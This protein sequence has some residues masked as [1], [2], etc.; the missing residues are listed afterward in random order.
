MGHNVYADLGFENSEEMLIKAELVSRIGRIIEER[1]LTQEQVA[2]LM[3]LDQPKVSN[4]LRGRFQD[5][6]LNRIFQ[7]LVALDEDVSIVVGPKSDERGR[8][9]VVA[10]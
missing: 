10:H 6:S 3:G 2:A 8:V 1:G 7:L 9:S 5:F 4:L